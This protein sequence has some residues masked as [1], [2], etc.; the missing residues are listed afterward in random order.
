MSSPVKNRI[1]TINGINS[2]SSKKPK[3]NTGHA[4]TSEVPV[5]HPP[6]LPQLMCSGRWHWP[7]V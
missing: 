4:F 1:D 3:E 5:L 6:V 7:S 2:I